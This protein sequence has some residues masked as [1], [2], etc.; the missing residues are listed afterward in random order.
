[1]QRLS[2][3]NFLGAAVMI[4][5]VFLQE[6]YGNW[7]WILFFAV[8]GIGWFMHAKG[9]NQNAIQNQDP[10]YIFMDKGP[11]NWQFGVGAW[12]VVRT[13]SVFFKIRGHFATMAEAF[14]KW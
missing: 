14:K 13:K 5:V 3:W 7:L 6:K 10:K 4:A 9:K 1:M 8:I 12:K 2:A 11:V